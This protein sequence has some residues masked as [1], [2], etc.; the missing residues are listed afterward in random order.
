MSPNFPT[1]FA[2]ISDPSERLALGEDLEWSKTN[3]GWKIALPDGDLFVNE[4]VDSEYGFV[5]SPT[6]VTRTLSKFEGVVFT[7]DFP[8]YRELV[9]EAIEEAR[10]LQSKLRYLREG[11]SYIPDGHIAFYE[12]GELR[13]MKPV[14]PLF[15][16]YPCMLTPIVIP[17]NIAQEVKDAIQTIARKHSISINSPWLIK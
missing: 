9:Y 14:N 12:N 8:L 13:W 6:R 11:L 7:G 5:D 17:E 1:T 16:D 15:V 3:A 10:E 2:Q 4:Q